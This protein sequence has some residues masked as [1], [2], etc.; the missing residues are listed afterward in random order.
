MKKDVTKGHLDL[1]LLT[2]L[3]RAPGH[4]YAVISALRDH[5]DGVF[6]LP[7]GSVYPALH[8]LE[9]LGLLGSV[10]QPVAGRRRRVYQITEH[11]T[12]ELQRERS[13]WQAL[14]TAVNAVMNAAATRPAVV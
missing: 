2:V 4:G 9:D 8:R 6:D 10:W 12:R 13:S 7:E 3:D 1:L 5:S 14:V 11:G